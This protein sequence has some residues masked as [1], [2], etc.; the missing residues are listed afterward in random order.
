MTN[1]MFVVVLLLPKVR[2]YLG[3][4]AVLLG[5]FLVLR[6]AVGPSLN[7][8]LLCWFLVLRRAVGPSLNAV[9]LGWFLVLRRAV[10]P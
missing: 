1:C 5:W 7:A 8:V 4:Y 6:R 9:L 10:W 3:L 2:V